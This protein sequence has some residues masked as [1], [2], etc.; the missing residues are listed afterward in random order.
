MSPPRRR[1]RYALI[2][3]FSISRLLAKIIHAVDR[4]DLDLADV[5]TLQ[6]AQRDLAAGRTTSPD[7]AIELRLRTHPFAANSENDIPA[8]HA[9]PV[10]GP[11][12][13]HAVNDQPALDLIC[14]H[15][16]ASRTISDPTPSRDPSV[17]ISAAPLQFKV[18]GEVKIARSSRYSQLPVKGR[19]DTTTAR[20]ASSRPP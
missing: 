20:V 5:D 19:R 4:A 18:G 11:F 14:R 13:R 2:T 8:L 3:H 6:Y 15:S 16:D 12:R 10:G 17:P 1:L 7:L 9:R